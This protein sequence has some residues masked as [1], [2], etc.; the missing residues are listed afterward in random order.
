MMDDVSL[1][2]IV[3]SESVKKQFSGS[4]ESNQFKQEH[5]VFGHVTQNCQL[6]KNKQLFGIKQVK[7]L[8]VMYLFFQASMAI[9][10]NYRQ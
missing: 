9:K 4:S 6:M 7:Q 3:V 10:M 8:T 5:L 1:C 2:P